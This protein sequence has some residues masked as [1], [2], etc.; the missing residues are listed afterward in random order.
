VNLEKKE[1]ASKRP[2]SFDPFLPYEEDLFV[3]KVEPN[4]V[5]LLNKFNALPLASLLVTRDF[6][7]QQDHANVADLTALLDCMRR[8]PGVGFYNRGSHSGSSQPHKHLQ[9]V[10][11]EPGEPCVPSLSPDTGLN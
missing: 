10:P 6:Q 11:L 8:M 3:E 1:T 9:L 2:P 7:P 5:V 4:H